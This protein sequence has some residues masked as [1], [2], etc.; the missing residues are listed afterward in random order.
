MS[1]FSRFVP[2]RRFLFTKSNYQHLD[3][4]APLSPSRYLRYFPSLSPNYFSYHSSFPRAVCRFHLPHFLFLSLS[5][6][7]SPAV[8]FRSRGSLVL[9]TARRA[10]TFIAASCGGW[11]TRSLQM[12]FQPGRTGVRIEEGE[13]EGIALF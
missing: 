11:T 1:L 13:G 2:Q 5:L 9:I 10:L 7:R 3:T 4:T 6:P 12:N 8:V